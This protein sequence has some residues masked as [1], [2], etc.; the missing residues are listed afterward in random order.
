MASGRPVIAYAAGGALE[1][2]I[3]GKTGMF[4]YD[5]EWESLADAIIRFKP[6]RFDSQFIKKH[7]YGFD[8]LTFKN[9][10]KDF[11]DQA[12]KK[13]QSHY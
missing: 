10:I 4:F 9:K 5:Q 8:Y 13:Y 2:I 1:T 7:A 12:Y 6:E 3:E 11:V